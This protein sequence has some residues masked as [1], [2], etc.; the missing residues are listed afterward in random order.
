MAARDVERK[1]NIVHNYELINLTLV[2]FWWAVLELRKDTLPTSLSPGALLVENRSYFD[3]TQ[4]AN[5]TSYHC[6]A[7][8]FYLAL[9]SRT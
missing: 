3:I 2:S 4:I 1:G 9:A 7:V 6:F 5:H 8:A